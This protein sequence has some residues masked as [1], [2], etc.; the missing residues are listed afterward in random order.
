MHGYFLLALS[1]AEPELSQA[2]TRELGDHLNDEDDE[3]LDCNDTMVFSLACHDLQSSARTSMK[4][5]PSTPSPTRAP[6]TLGDHVCEVTSFSVLISRKQEDPDDPLDLKLEELQAGMHPLWRYEAL[7]ALRDAEYKA[8][9]LQM[10]MAASQDGVG[11]PPAAWLRSHTRNLNM[12][13]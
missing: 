6:R 4:P 10:Q 5:A 13:S 3:A 1:Q 9:L 11:D 8:D 12:L 7:A 2:S